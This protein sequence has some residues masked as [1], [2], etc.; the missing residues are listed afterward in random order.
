MRRYQFVEC[1]RAIAV[2]LIINSHAKGIWPSDILSFGGGLSLGMFYLLSGFLLRGVYKSTSFV[3]WY[4]KKVCRIYIPLWIYT[5][6]EVLLNRVKISSFQDALYYYLFPTN[7][8]FAIS[9]AILYALYYATLKYNLYKSFRIIIP[10]IF[11]MC[12]LFI[13]VLIFRPSVAFLSLE[14]LTWNTFSL[15]SPFLC[16]QLIWF[17]CMLIGATVTYSTDNK[18]SQLPYYGLIVLGAVLYC[19]PK[20]VEKMYGMSMIEAFLPVSYIVFSI[21]MFLLLQNKESFFKKKYI[22]IPHYTIFK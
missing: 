8:W 7:Y 19:I 14:K 3:N 18:K 22:Q 5:T 12:A 21:G 17:T 15:D 4:M 11:S 16:M 2:V 6:I 1:I 9:I 20:F 10:M 13:V